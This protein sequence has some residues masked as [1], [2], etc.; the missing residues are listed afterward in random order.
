[1]QRILGII[2]IAIGVSG[3][4]LSFAGLLAG[5]RL[6]DNIGAGLEANL[7]LTIESLDTVNETLLLSKDTVG[8]MNEALLA[9]E[10]TADNV[11]IAIDDTQ[12]LLEQASQV[13]TEDVPESIEAF[14]DTLPALTDVAATIDDTLRTLSSFGFE[15]SILGVPLGFDLGIDYDPEVPFDQSVEDLGQSLEGLPEDLRSL[16]MHLDQ[17]N[18]N[19]SMIGNNIDTISGN[20]STINETV[21]EVEPLIDDYLLIVT[22]LSDSARQTR[23]FVTQQLDQV[24]VIVT[25]ASIWLGLTQFAPIYLGW[26][27]LVRGRGTE[28]VVLEK[29]DDKDVEA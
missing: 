6:V 10:E 7:T 25:I 14:Q 23:S 8:Q 17:T 2:M 28:V 21:S 5:H 3:L 29:D 12:P 27:L 15:R 20:L 26:E 9:V 13:T 4:L 16:K 1:M 11:V 19:L 18:R 22:D 24:K